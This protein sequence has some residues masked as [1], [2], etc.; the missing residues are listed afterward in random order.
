MGAI[1]VLIQDL[2]TLFEVREF[3]N[4]KVDMQKTLYFMRELGYKVPGDFRWSRLGPYSYELDNLIERMTFQGYLEY[5]GRYE[6]REKSFRFVEPRVTEKMRNFFQEMEKVMNKNSYDQVAF[7]E[8]I[9]SL[10]FLYKNS[11]N[12]EKKAIFDKLSLMKPE[13]SR[14]FEPLIEDAW[15]FLERQGMLK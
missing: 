1:E 11:Q 2:K 13:R 6:I 5:S 7:I 9:A 3:V 4:G 10:H 14:A 12:K 15:S 8:C